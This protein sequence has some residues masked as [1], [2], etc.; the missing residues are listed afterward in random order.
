MDAKQKGI[1]RFAYIMLVLSIIAVL[2]GVG[3]FY[4]FIFDESV[5]TSVGAKRP[6]SSLPL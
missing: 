1:S 3:V 5:S 6:I 2:L 4:W